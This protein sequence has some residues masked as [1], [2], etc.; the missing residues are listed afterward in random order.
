MSS[1]ATFVLVHGAWH[2]AWCWRRVED[3]LRERGHRVFCPTLSGLGE[4]SH[5]LSAEVDLDTHI[6]DVVNLIEWEDLSNIVL[7]GHSYGGFVISGVAERLVTSRISSMMFVDAFVPRDGESFVESI[8]V[9]DFRQYLEGFVVRHAVGVT[10]PG[11]ATFNVNVADRAWVDARCTP[12]PTASI[13]Q[14]IRLSG[15]RERV[16]RK[17]Y[18]RADGFRSRIFDEVYARLRDERG[19]QLHHLDCG[20]D[21]MIDA[22]EALTALLLDALS[23]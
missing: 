14:P 21:A 6:D 2:G 1:A 22:P 13:T 12:H 15:G 18:V 3:R 8:T 4:R 20:H 16:H 17:F 7:V 11:A 19:W 5:L 9:P 23:I 10:P